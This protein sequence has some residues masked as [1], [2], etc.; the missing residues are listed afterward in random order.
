MKEPSLV[1]AFLLRQIGRC[2]VT[3]VQGAGHQC[4]SDPHLT[5]GMEILSMAYAAR[6]IESTAAML[7]Q[8]LQAREIRPCVAA[9]TRQRHGDDTFRP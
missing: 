4:P 6:G 1:W 8:F 5:Q 2:E 9:D 7:M 3:V